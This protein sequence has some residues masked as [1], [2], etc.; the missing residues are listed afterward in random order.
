MAARSTAQRCSCCLAIET[1]I[2]IFPFFAD[3]DIS[4]KHCVAHKA[5]IVQ[6][7]F[8]VLVIAL[9]SRD[10]LSMLP[11]KSRIPQK[12]RQSWDSNKAAP[13]I[14][15]L[16]YSPPTRAPGLNDRKEATARAYSLR[17]HSD[18]CR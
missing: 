8:E 10:A 5:S 7:I 12:S 13:F 18:A 2:S 14:S 17:A 16:A 4:M 9:S 6:I 11:P 1:A 3:A 15:L